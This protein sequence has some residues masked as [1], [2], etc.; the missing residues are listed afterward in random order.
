LIKKTKSQRILHLITWLK[1][2]FGSFSFFM[3]W[4]RHFPSTSCITES[5]KSSPNAKKPKV[6]NYSLS[7]H[8]WI[9]CLTTI[10]KGHLILL[11]RL[12]W[13]YQFAKVTVKCFCSNCHLHMLDNTIASKVRNPYT[14]QTVR[15]YQ[16]WW[17][18]F[19]VKLI[20]ELY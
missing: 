7:V 14:E 5:S 4:Y 8:I 9:L 18:V 17:F 2:L 6:I 15:V 16:C 12:L 1:E 3:I 20:I 19:Y 10:N 11:L 13:S